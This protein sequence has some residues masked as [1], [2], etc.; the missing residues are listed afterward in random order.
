MPRQAR[1]RAAG[2]PWHVRQRANN[3][4]ACFVEPEDRELYLGLLG[5][6]APKTGCAIHAY[7]LMT[8][9]IHLLVTPQEADGPSRLMK[10]VGER[11]VRRFN[12]RRRR[13]GTLW[14]GRF[15]SN[16]VQTERYLLTLHRYIEM[17]PVRASMVG[18]PR[19][20]PWS[21]YRCNAEGEASL[22]VVPHEL[23]LS[24]GTS[25][26]SRRKVYAEAFAA[27]I[28]QAE[29]ER[30]RDAINSGFALGNREFVSRLQQELQ[31]KVARG[32]NGRPRKPKAYDAAELLW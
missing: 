19:A 25:C 21:S 15:R 4:I 3:G 29:L 12:V 13:Y 17:N 28:P 26:E 6:L 14:E 32:V 1:L 31:R 27:S 5:E 11:Y 22:V 9:H 10:Q 8:N 2:I 16:L 24:L 18:H 20:F 30:I 7:V 23:Y